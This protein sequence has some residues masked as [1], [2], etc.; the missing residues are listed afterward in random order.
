MQKDFAGMPLYSHAFQMGILVNSRNIS[1]KIQAFIAPLLLC[2]QNYDV[3]K[4]DD[5]LKGLQMLWDLQ[6]RM[7]GLAIWWDSEK[8]LKVSAVTE[9]SRAE[10][11]FANYQPNERHVHECKIPPAMAIIFPFLWTS[12]EEAYTDKMAALEAQLLKDWET[13]IPT[14]K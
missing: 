4:Y 3:H 1:S 14:L 5:K 13:G 8:R 2:A 6:Q 10:F 12:I 9:Q 7:S 11:E